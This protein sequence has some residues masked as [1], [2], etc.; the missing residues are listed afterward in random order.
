MRLP[1]RERVVELIP[2]M[3]RF[4]V[5]GFLNTV[6]DLAV[7]NVL[8]FTFALPETHATLFPFFAT[9]GFIAATLNSYLWNRSWTFRSERGRA[10]TELPRFYGVTIVSFLVNVGLSSLLVWLHPF[11]GLSQTLWANAAKLVAVGVSLCLNFIGYHKL[12]FREKV[13]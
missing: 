12:V 1:S 10:T 8:L 2:R 9:A 3:L 4:G 11:P 7:L 13:D 5:V 6:V